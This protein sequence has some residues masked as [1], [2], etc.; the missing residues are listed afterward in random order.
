[1]S[2][3][4]E[5]HRPLMHEGLFI[6]VIIIFFFSLVSWFFATTPNLGNDISAFFKGFALVQVPN[7]TYLLPAPATPGAYPTIFVVAAQWCLI[8]GGFEIFLLI[9]RF[10][11]RSSSWRKVE[12]FTTIIWW[13]GAYYL[14]NMFLG[15]ATTLVLWFAFWGAIITLLGAQLVIRGI[16]LAAISKFK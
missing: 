15:S 12:T 2:E 9:L 16:I 7:T 3:P 6:A 10:G 13:F 14:I 4:R 5:T 1:L 11:V 8:W